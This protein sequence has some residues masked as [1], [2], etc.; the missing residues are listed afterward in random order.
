MLRP[1]LPFPSLC[2]LFN[3]CSFSVF[4]GRHPVVGTVE[5]IPI[6]LRAQQLSQCI[7]APL[8][9][10]ETARFHAHMS[11]WAWKSRVDAVRPQL[12]GPRGGLG[13]RLPCLSSPVTLQLAQSGF[14]APLRSVELLSVPPDLGTH[15]VILRAAFK[16]L[17][18]CAQR[19][20]FSRGWLLGS[21]SPDGN[22]PLHP[23]WVWWPL[24]APPRSHRLRC[25]L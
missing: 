8:S 5:G 25:C 9:V 22:C 10:G 3:K 16:A 1:F 23:P 6:V 17:E 12:C 7:R 20:A 15:R 14:Q 2:N 13:A 19:W 18:A 21:Q 24:W 4:S 11:S